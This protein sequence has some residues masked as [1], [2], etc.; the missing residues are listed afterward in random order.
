MQQRKGKC[1]LGI[2][3]SIPVF[4]W[5]I[6]CHSIIILR[7]LI[8]KKPLRTAWDWSLWSL[9]T[10]CLC[11]ASHTFLLWPIQDPPFRSSLL[12]PPRTSMADVTNLSQHSLL[13]NLE[14]ISEFLLTFYSRY[15][16]PIDQHL[17][18]WWK[19]F[20]LAGTVEKTEGIELEGSVLVT[21]LITA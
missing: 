7:F 4:F 12:P 1:W 19:L 20:A 9:A 21:T 10:Y 15:P 8:L 13:M 18:V 3:Y 16:I 2:N 6:K 5:A 11:W 14:K 17:H